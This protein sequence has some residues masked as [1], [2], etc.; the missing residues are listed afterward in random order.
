MNSP[1]NSSNRLQ[2]HLSRYSTAGVFCVSLV[3]ALVSVIP[4]YNKL[5]IAQEQD[6]QAK[7]SNRTLAAEQVQQSSIEVAEQ[8]TSRTFARKILSDYV[9][10]KASLTELQEL[11]LFDLEDAID[12]NDSLVGVSRFDRTDQLLV[13]VGVDST[14]DLSD[15]L[16]GETDESIT[17]GPIAIDNR[18]HLLVSSPIFSEQQERIGRDI[19]V[20]RMSNMERLVAEYIGLGETGE[21]FL[22]QEQGDTL[23]LFFPLRNGSQVL[24]EHLASLL[25]GAI[26]HDPTEIEHYDNQIIAFGTLPHTDWIIAVQMDR[27][28]LYGAVN[29]DLF[30]VGLAVFGV[31]TIATVGLVFVLRPLI[32]RVTDADELEKEVLAKT[33]AFEELKQTQ[34]QLFQAE[35]MSSLGQLVAGIAHEINNPVGFLKGNIQ[36]AQNYI[37]DLLGLIDLYQEKMPNPDADIEDEIKEIDLEFIREDLP[38]IINSMNSGV[39]R[40]RNISDGL[41]IF[42]RQDRDY[43]TAFNIHEGIE[44]TILILK[45]RTKSNEQRPAVEVVKN[46]GDLP[47]VQCFPGQLNQVFMNILANAIDAF[48]EANQGKTFEEIKADPNIITITTSVVDKQVQIQIQDNACGMKRET[49]ER[50]FEQ[51]FTTKE[52]GKGTGLGMA[53]AHQIIT[54]KHGGSIECSSEFGKGTIFTIA[55]SIV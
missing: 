29:R 21:M 42:S 1:S 37:K 32:K 36:P 38:N 17:V 9:Q 48:E 25:H 49:I 20:F 16:Q 39:D 31:S 52:V 46:Y 4:L 34:I 3:V 14:L 28:E 11:S 51:G 47:E 22:A 55:L 27:Q 41:R 10:G 50:I 6:L 35:K 18:P 53:I 45:H 33:T 40:I 54:E 5:K 8:V 24:P 19:A 43:K 30:F 2:R 12:Q 13:H 7:L 15:I 26:A 44:S 23:A